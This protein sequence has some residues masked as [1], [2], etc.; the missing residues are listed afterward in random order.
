MITGPRAGDCSV[1]R[2]NRTRSAECRAASCRGSSWQ[3]AA[4]RRAG[5]EGAQHGNTYA[6]IQGASPLPKGMEPPALFNETKL[7]DINSTPLEEINKLPDFCSRKC[8]RVRSARIAGAPMKCLAER[9]QKIFV[10]SPLE[11]PQGWG[12]RT[13][14]RFKFI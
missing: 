10:R 7:I 11:A 9:K 5:G 4:E 8:I 13:I 6:N 14:Y 3:A 1:R 2:S 12:I